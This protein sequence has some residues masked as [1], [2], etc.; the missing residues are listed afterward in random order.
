MKK[1]IGSL[2]I[3]ALAVLNLIMTSADVYANN[4]SE[5]LD[6]YAIFEEGGTTSF[7]YCRTCTM[8]EGSNPDQ[9]QVCKP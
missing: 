2:I 9:L 7:I 6:C 1:I 5:K 3:T 8:Q 4:E